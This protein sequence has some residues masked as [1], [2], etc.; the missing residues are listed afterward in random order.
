ML[1]VHPVVLSIVFSELGHL[2]SSVEVYAESP[3]CEFIPCM[4]SSFTNTLQSLC[5]DL[6]MA[7]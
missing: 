2:V 6:G 7:L 4:V 5:R 3:C 1:Y